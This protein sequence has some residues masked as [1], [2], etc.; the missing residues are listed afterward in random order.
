MLEREVPVVYPSPDRC[1]IDRELITHY[2]DNGFLV[3]DNVFS[4]DEVTAFQQEVDRLRSD[5]QTRASGEVIREPDS[6][7]VRS[8]FRVHQVSS[9]FRRLATDPRLTDLASYL[10]GDQIY[11]HQSRVNYKPGFRGREFYWHSDFETWHV[12]DGMPSMRALSMSITLTGNYATNGPL[13]LI[14]GSHLRYVVCEGETPAEH[15]R[16][17]LRKQEYGIPDDNSVRQ[18]AR[19]NGIVAATGTPGSVIVFD[20][21]LMHGSGSNITPYARSNVFFVYN[22]LSNRVGNP[23]CDRPPR[24]EYLCSRE[25]ITPL[26]QAKEAEQPETRGSAANTTRLVTNSQAEADDE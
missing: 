18:L 3:L 17:S 16:N 22:A 4:L 13:L 26:A 5:P 15:F 8:V 2:R 12:E 10:L 19:D 23:Y 14:P 11:V 24:P 9:V 20:C 6:G 21:N 1:P 25:T 7:E